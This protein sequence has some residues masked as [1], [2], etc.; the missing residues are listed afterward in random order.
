MRRVLLRRRIA[1]AVLRCGRRVALM[2]VVI[3]L[4]GIVGH[5]KGRGG[6]AGRGKNVCGRALSACEPPG[7]D[8]S[9]SCGLEDIYLSF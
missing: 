1:T 7:W 8:A 4:A 2:L 5:P 6:D 9:I 3:P